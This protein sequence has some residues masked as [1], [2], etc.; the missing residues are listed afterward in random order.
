M[1]ESIDLEFQEVVRPPMW[2][3]ALNSGS[4]GTLITEPFPNPGSGAL[5]DHG[6]HI[7]KRTKIF[8]KNPGESILGRE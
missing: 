7:W 5:L 1:S 2:V 3:L 8:L 4:Q 6:L